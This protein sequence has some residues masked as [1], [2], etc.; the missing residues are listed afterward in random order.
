MRWV[1]TALLAGCNFV[2]GL[3]ETRP[4]ID[5]DG[6][7]VD[8]ELDNCP[9]TSNSDQRDSDDDTFGD[10]CDVCPNEQT[11]SNHDEDDDGVGDECDV[12]PAHADFHDDREPDGVG[13]ACDDVV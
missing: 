6:D 10:A 3:D 7:N 5:P 1:V 12:C 2:Y 4:A 8:I 13:D 9:T 11:A